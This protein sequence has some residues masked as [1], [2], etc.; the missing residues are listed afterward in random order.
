M[1]RKPMVI[2]VGYPQLRISTIYPQHHDI[3]MDWIV[4][5]AEPP[6]RRT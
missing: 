2:G 6:V 3:P 1:A 5:G 4:P